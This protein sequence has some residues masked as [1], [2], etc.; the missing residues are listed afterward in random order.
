MVAASAQNGVGILLGK[1]FGHPFQH[2]TAIVGWPANDIVTFIQIVTEQPNFG[3]AKR[4][5]DRL[6][7]GPT[8]AN[9]ECS[10]ARFY[11]PR[12]QIGQ[13]PIRRTNEQRNT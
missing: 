13:A 11:G 10:R 5:T 6:A 3:I 2:V 12:A 8:G 1:L 4:F 9:R 7:N